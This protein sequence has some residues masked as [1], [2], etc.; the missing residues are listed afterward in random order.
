MSNTPY[1]CQILEVENS[2]AF[3][4]QALT[5]GMNTDEINTDGVNADEFI[6]VSVPESNPEAPNGQQ[7]E[8][9]TS[10]FQKI[11]SNQITILSGLN[12]VAKS[13]LKLESEVELMRKE[14]SGEEIYKIGDENP[15]TSKKSEE[16]ISN[17]FVNIASEAEV[18]TLETLFEKE[19]MVNTFKNHFRKIIGGRR[20]KTEA[21]KCV[22]EVLN[23]M[24]A[25][26]F[27]LGCSWKGGSNE[28]NV[29]KFG[30]IKYENVLAAIINLIREVSDDECPESCIQKAFESKMRNRHALCGKRS[31]APKLRPTGIAY[32]NS[33]QNGNNN[34]KNGD[35]AKAN[36]TGYDSKM[37]DPEAND[38][39]L[40]DSESSDE[41][42]QSNDPNTCKF[43]PI[44]E[45]SMNQLLKIR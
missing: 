27:W 20:P 5:D 7:F 32:K 29:K 34:E 2:N 26:T 15:S 19:E 41:I 9:L 13:V 4:R 43:S 1:E 42:I 44:S 31:W 6:Y 33:K 14:R 22:H 39:C 36:D 21:A 11:L 8:I 16:T 3:S 10:Y 23:K 17:H 25:K 40:V 45:D 37:V 18:K 30:M 28:K 38:T 24:F 12:S 35:D